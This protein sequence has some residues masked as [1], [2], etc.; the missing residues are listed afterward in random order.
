MARTIITI[1]AEDR[2]W[3]DNYSHRVNLSSAEIIRRAI[4]EYRRQVSK[5]DLKRVLEATTGKWKSIKAD[6][7][8][9]VNDLRKEWEP[10]K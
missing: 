9:Y 3:L 2:K 5:G 1:A 6:S 7:Q 10:W 8:E 4:K